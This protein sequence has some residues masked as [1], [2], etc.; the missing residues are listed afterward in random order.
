M[1]NFFGNIIDKKNELIQKISEKKEILNDEEFNLYEFILKNGKILY[2]PDNFNIEQFT[3]NLKKYMQDELSLKTKTSIIE[4]NMYKIEYGRAKGIK[5]TFGVGGEFNLFM[6]QFEQEIMYL[7]KPVSWSK[8]PFEKEAIS[9]TS[10]FN[11]SYKEEIT[12]YIQ[13]NILQE[14]LTVNKPR[15]IIYNNRYIQTIPFYQKIWFYSV[16]EKDEIMLAKLNIMSLKGY[17]E[18]EDSEKNLDLI[19]IMTNINILIA[20]FDEKGEIILF[21]KISGKE[22]DVKRNIIRNEIRMGTVRCMSERSNS[23]LFSEIE[24]AVLLEQNERLRELSRL[25]YINGKVEYSLKILKI[26]IAEEENPYDKLCKYYIDLREKKIEDFEQSEAT[27]TLTEIMNAERTKEH[28]KT[29]SKKW[30]ISHTDKALILQLMNNIA[31][32][33]EQKDGLNLF[34]EEV[35]D[36]FLKKNKDS[37]NRTLF[38]INYCKYLIDCKED[39]SAIKILN[40]LIKKLPDESVL[41]LLPSDRT[42]LTSASSG[43][44]LKISVLDL[45]IDANDNEKAKEYILKTAQLQ[46][47][48]KKRLIALKENSENELTINASILLDLLSKGNIKR[49]EKK[50]NDIK[51]EEL[52]KKN[53][54]NNLRH[55]ATQKHGGFYPF[56]RWI[57]KIK[58]EDYSTVKMF[59]EKLSPEEHNNIYKDL[60]EIK[61]AFGIDN[62]EIYFARGEKS[63]GIRG[64]EGEPPFIIIGSEHIN[65][66]S[67]FFMTS[68]ELRFAIGEE[69]AHIYFNHSRIT[70]NDVWRGAADK[71]YLLLDTLLGIVPVAGVIGKSIRNVSKLQGLSKL[72]VNVEKLS[73]GGN[74]LGSALMLDKFYQKIANKRTKKDKKHELLAVSRIMQFTADRAGLMFSGDLKASVRAIILSGK[75]NFNYMTKINKIGLYAFITEQNNNG[76]FK[77]QDIAVRLANLFAFYISNDYIELRT[78]KDK[79]IATI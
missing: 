46:P 14:I 48:N 70:S 79:R 55:P 42:N 73:A 1:K 38:E 25:N 6:M 53:I 2:L 61:K 32:T 28:L 16:C 15:K 17:E 11:N 58:K 59:S 21:K 7:L 26:L 12:T 41:D 19:F 9:F 30:N 29:L 20:G 31:K 43:Q 8:N 24:S 64:Y 33:K 45:L 52:S 50:I 39:K 68:P 44:L 78:Q 10:W 3:E 40:R 63:V 4:K 35:R 49:E 69:A 22:F 65:K 23:K 37:I 74:I 54:E 71:G 72:L 60:K 13:K 77:H 66:T 62:L 36:E 18:L 75:N 47:L 27:K 51:F 57:S 76:T 67:D 56:Q 5:K 34:Y